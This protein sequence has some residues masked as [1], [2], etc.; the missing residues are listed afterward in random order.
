MDIR[1]IQC[2]NNQMI[3][4]S[5]SPFHCNEEGFSLMDGLLHYKGCIWVGANVLAQHHIFQALHCS[6]VGGHSGVPATYECIKPVFALPKLKT[7][8]QQMI[9]ACAVCQQAKIEHVKCLVCY[10]LYQYHLSP[11]KW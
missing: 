4:L 10:S 1:M 8:V 3:E 11:G 2:Q 5:T 9:T 7:M 6:G